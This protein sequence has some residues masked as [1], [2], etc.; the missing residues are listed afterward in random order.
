MGILLIVGVAALILLAI[1]GALLLPPPLCYG[2]WTGIALIP[3]ISRFSQLRACF[4]NK[5]RAGTT[6]LNLGYL[7]R[8]SGGLVLLAI[9][10]IV[11]WFVWPSRTPAL[12]ILQFG[13]VVF[14]ITDAGAKFIASRKPTLVTETGIYGPEGIILWDKIESHQWFKQRED[15]LLVAKVKGQPWP[16]DEKKL[17]IPTSLMADVDKLLRERI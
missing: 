6:L 14:F 12:V 11:L 1:W 16:L 5:T 7:N 17:R 10:W 13:V 3:A 9:T 8:M 15:V 2:V 4:F